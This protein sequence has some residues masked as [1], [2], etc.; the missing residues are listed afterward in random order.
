MKMYLVGFERFVITTPELVC[1]DLSQ[2]I[3][4][5]Q[6]Q[7]ETEL[8]YLVEPMRCNRNLTKLKCK[9][10]IDRIQNLLYILGSRYCPFGVRD[11]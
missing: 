10:L 4:L 9:N 5:S 2:S 8:V 6:A 7:S 11:L 1:S 3:E